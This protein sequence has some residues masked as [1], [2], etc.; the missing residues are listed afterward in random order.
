[1]YTQSTNAVWPS[2]VP[3]G[4]ETLQRTSDV[5]LSGFTSVVL[6]AVWGLLCLLGFAIIFW[7]REPIGGVIV[8]AAPTLVAMILKPTFALCVLMMVLPTGSLAYQGSFSFSVDRGVG[9]AVAVGVT[10]NF[11]FTRP[12]LRVGSKAL[13]VVLAYSLWIALAVLWAPDTDAELQY[14]KT[15]LQLVVLVFVVYWVLDTNPEST[16]RWALRSFVVGTLATLVIA[17]ITGTAA[18]AVK[19]STQG[20]YGAVIGSAAL[21]ANKVAALH[22]LAFVTAMY[23]LVHDKKL[24]WRMIHVCALVALPYMILKT[25]S[26][27]AAVAL[28]GALLL[29]LLIT[30]ELIRKPGLSIVVVILLLLVAGVAAIAVQSRGLEEGVVERLTDWGGVVDAVRYRFEVI[31]VAVRAAIQYP[32]GTT[33]AAWELR[34]GS[35]HYPHN[36]FF[37]VVGVYGIVGAG[38]F[39]TMFIILIVTVT[40]MS[41]GLD[42]WYARAVLLFLLIMGQDYYQ[43][44]T[45]AFWVFVV[46]ILAMSRISAAPPWRSALAHGAW[47]PEVGKP[48]PTPGSRN[49]ANVYGKRMESR[50]FGR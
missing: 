26:R 8:I 19:E 1:M 6:L 23:L 32:L 45:K 20:R 2:S 4:Y 21:D 5:R 17:Q 24:V 27:G 16:V 3:Y 48:P 30:R 50:S 38:L 25:G 37:Y 43:L 49:E 34:T 46:F 44:R 13:W 12:G 42:K 9:I 22:A 36:D 35:Y 18:Q 11:R 40:R 7:Q 15:Q 10:G 47:G 33:N 28:M 31:T 39:G 14:A 29:P 41:L